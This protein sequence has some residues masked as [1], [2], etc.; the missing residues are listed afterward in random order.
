MSHVSEN[1]ENVPE[2]EKPET[3]KNM[4]NVTPETSTDGKNVNQPDK[5]ATVGED[6]DDDDDDPKR[7]AAENSRDGSTAAETGKKLDNM[8]TESP[9]HRITEEDAINRIL[10]SSPSNSS[11]VGVTEVIHADPDSTDCPSNGSSNENVCDI[12]RIED[13]NLRTVLGLGLSAVNTDLLG[14]FTIRGDHENCKWIENQIKKL[15]IVPF[16][17]QKEIQHFQRH[18]VK[19]V[20]S[21]L[22]VI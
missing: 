22:N 5:C 6:D 17:L 3:E 7:T 11:N 10:N 12:T 18:Y 8:E 4:E 21:K 20:S 2:T 13:Y 15:K 14:Y 16:K 9:N 19:D 1:A